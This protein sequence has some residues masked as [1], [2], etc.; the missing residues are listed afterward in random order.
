MTKNSLV[1]GIYLARDPHQSA[2]QTVSRL[3]PGTALPV[4]AAAVARLLVGHVEGGLL[5]DFRVN[6]DATPPSSGDTGAR[7][8][9]AFPAGSG[10]VGK[11]R[12]PAGKSVRIVAD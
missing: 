2:P 8:L 7:A 10:N 5:V 9:H 4:H 11:N 12:F 6:E 3:S 1:D